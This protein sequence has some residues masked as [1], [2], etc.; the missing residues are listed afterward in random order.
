M[1]TNK[2]AKTVL[3]FGDSLVFGKIPVPEGSRYDSETRFTGIIQKELGDKVEIIEEGLR[4]RVIEGEN[5]FFPYR[6]GLEQFGPTFG[7]HYPIDLLILFLGTNDTNSGF[8]K[9]PEE[10]VKSFDKYLETVD[11]WCKHFDFPK[12]EILFIAPPLVDEEKSYKAFKDIFKGAGEK[13]KQLSVAYENY[14]KKNNLHFLDSSKVVNPSSV[15]GIH[16]TREGNEVLGKEIAKKIKEI[17][18]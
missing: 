5:A 1:N 3:I 11:W 4:G 17:L 7:S 14:A 6:N 18:I 2:N 13:S 10:F 16:L 15:D 8:T 9:N 12:P